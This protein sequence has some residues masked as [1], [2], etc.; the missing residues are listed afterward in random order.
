MAGRQDGAS[1]AVP[2]APSPLAE[3]VRAWVDVVDGWS[4]WETVPRGPSAQ[5]LKGVAA[6]LH[7]LLQM[8]RADG[9]T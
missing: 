6:C 5:E 4:K 3:E 2:P 8:M 7:R 9:E 1:R